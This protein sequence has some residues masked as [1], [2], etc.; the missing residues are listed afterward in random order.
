VYRKLMFIFSMMVCIF[1]FMADSSTMPVA[2][3]ESA[4]LNVFAPPV[5]KAVLV[6]LQN[7]YE[8]NHPDIKI[9]YKFAPPGQLLAQIKQ[10]A[11]PDIFISAATKQIDALAADDLIIPATRINITSNQIVLIVA[12]NS[13]LSLTDFNDLTK[14][15]VKAYGLA[16]AAAAPVGQYGIEVLQSIGIWDAVK[17][18]ALITPDGCSI[19]P[20]VEQGKVQAGIVFTTNAATSDKV[21]IVA[22]APPGSHKPIIFPGVVLRNAGSPDLAVDFLNFLTADGQENIFKKNGFVSVN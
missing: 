14:N 16:D 1:T 5:L 17:D 10:G 13:P 20:L 8:R 11:S 22:V 2:A 6:D 15:S 12:K 7:E 3:A 19:V 18:K 4:K 9:V 21:K